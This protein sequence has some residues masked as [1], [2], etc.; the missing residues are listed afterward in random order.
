MKKKKLLAISK[1]KIRPRHKNECFTVKYGN[2]KKKPIAFYNLQ[3][4]QFTKTFCLLCI[5]GCPN[6]CTVR[7]EQLLI[8]I[9]LKKKKLVALGDCFNRPRAIDN[10]AAAYSESFGAAHGFY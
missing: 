10:L 7:A 8:P 1:I 2:N 4:K 9:N 5:K 3:V 6:S